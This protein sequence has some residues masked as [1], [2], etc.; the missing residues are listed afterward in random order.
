MGLMDKI[1]IFAGVFDPIHLGHTRF[2]QASIKDK[3][4]DKVFVMVEKRPKNKKCLASYEHRRKM[5]ELAIALVP[6]AEVY[7]TKSEHYPITASWTEIKKANPGAKLF[8]LVGDDVAEHISEW[9]GAKQLLAEV[10][11]I[12]A[13]RN[14]SDPYSQVSSLKARNQLKAGDKPALEPKVLQY[15]QA[16]GLYSVASS[17]AIGE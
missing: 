13:R 15:I 8:L 9:E 6:P 17:L 11:L 1:G 16:N 14:N 4:L 7:D 3:G 5:V 10:E 2:M 12:V